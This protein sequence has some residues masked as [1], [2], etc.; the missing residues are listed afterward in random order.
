MSGGSDRIANGDE[1]G[2]RRRAG[3]REGKFGHGVT[4][5]SVVGGGAIKL[6][7]QILL[8]DLKVT[9]GHADVLCPSICMRAGK[10][11]PRRS[12]VVAKVWTKAVWRGQARTAF[13]RSC[14][15]PMGDAER[16]MKDIALGAGLWAEW[17]GL[18]KGHVLGGGT[19]AA[20]GRLP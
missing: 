20:Q 6:P 15:R 13:A 7:L 3:R 12:M 1:R 17:I 14:W 11:T 19:K 4:T 10:L 8:R 9:H 16:V 5:G 18:M 2:A